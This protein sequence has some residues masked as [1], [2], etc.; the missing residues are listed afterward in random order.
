VRFASRDLARDFEDRHGL[1]SR[2]C[3]D[4]VTQTEAALQGC[5]RRG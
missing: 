2:G 3:V 1:T 4:L 5:L